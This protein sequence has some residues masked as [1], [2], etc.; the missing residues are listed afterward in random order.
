MLSK[1]DYVH[2]PDGRLATPPHLDPYL[3]KDAPALDGLAHILAQLFAIGPRP[4]V[5]MLNCGGT[6]DKR[7]INITLQ[8]CCASQPAVAMYVVGKGRPSWDNVFVSS[9]E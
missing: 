4:L 1:L 5:T 3:S 2:K 7:L 8:R 9:K 6:C